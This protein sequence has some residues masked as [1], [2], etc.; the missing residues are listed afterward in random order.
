MGNWLH[1]DHIPQVREDRQIRLGEDSGAPGKSGVH[2][3]CASQL[4]CHTGTAGDGLNKSYLLFL[5][6]S[7]LCC[8][9][10]SFY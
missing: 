6:T 1:A 4:V 7:D 5:M 8:P 9:G 3:G 10:G 2:I